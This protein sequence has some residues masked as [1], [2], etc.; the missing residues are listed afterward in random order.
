MTLPSG[1]YNETKQTASEFLEKLLESENAAPTKYL[2]LYK[3]K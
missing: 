3:K 1:F 2:L